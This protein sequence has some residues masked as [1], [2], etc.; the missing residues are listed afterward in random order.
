MSARAWY[1]TLD[2]AERRRV[3]AIMRG[4]AT[5]AEIGAL[6]GL[7]GRRV[8]QAV[9]DSAAKRR[10]RR[11]RYGGRCAA[12]S[13]FTTSPAALHCK[14]CHDGIHP[15]SRRLR[16]VTTCGDR[17]CREPKAPGSYMCKAHGAPGS[18]VSRAKRAYEQELYL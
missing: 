18:P 16:G 17:Y 1:E 13:N 5:N 15:E 3:L 11:E 9:T 8:S 10:A 12:C 4:H 6:V 14:D 2:P 7:D